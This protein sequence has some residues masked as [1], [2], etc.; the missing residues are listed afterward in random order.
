MSDLAMVIH[1]SLT[2]CYFFTRFAQNI[3]AGWIPLALSH[4]ATLRRARLA[5]GCNFGSRE[6]MEDME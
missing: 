5:Q 4:V 6:M 3:S 1:T 2:L